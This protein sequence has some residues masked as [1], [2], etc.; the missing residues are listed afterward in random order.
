MQTNARSQ[1]TTSKKQKALSSDRRFQKDSLTVASNHSTSRT[2]WQHS[3]QKAEPLFGR[4]TCT[5]ATNVS[6][7]G[8]G[9]EFF[10]L[11]G[12]VNISTV[13]PCSVLSPQTKSTRAQA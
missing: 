3:M 7:T 8:L 1:L 2:P 4:P 13:S 9:N 10:Q 6:L 5:N 12:C 11:D